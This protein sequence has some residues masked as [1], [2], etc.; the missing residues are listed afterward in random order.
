MDNINYQLSMNNDQLIKTL[1][2]KY[3]SGGDYNPDRNYDGC[4]KC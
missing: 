3:C 4:K 1:A 2:A